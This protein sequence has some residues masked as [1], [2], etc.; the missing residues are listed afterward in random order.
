MQ[1]PTIEKPKRCWKIIPNLVDYERTVAAF[2]WESARRELNGLPNA[3]GLNIG[4][5]NEKCHRM[6]GSRRGSYGQI[7]PID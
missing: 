3:P 6:V 1:W 4:I 5:L 2:S 7:S